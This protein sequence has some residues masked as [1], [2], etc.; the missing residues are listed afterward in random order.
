[1]YK[2]AT[3]ITAGVGLH[4]FIRSGWED[5]ISQNPY[6]YVTETRKSPVYQL[7]FGK[8]VGD[9]ASF[10]AFFGYGTITSIYYYRNLRKVARSYTDKVLLFGVKGQYHLYEYFNVPSELDPYIAIGGGM[11][12]IRDEQMGETH[13]SPFYMTHVGARYYIH[14][15]ASIYAELGLG[16]ALFNTG[17]SFRF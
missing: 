16:T 2:G 5:L 11:K 6:G 10:S 7:S 3:T 9:H 1:M 13:Y 14:P 4:S 15:S 17:L 12:Q 8:G